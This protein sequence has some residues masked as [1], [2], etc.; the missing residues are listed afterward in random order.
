MINNL[1]NFIY[2]NKI[3]SRLKLDVA[4]DNNVALN[5][6]K[7]VGFKTYNNKEANKW[8]NSNI[9]KL[10]NIDSKKKMLIYTL[11]I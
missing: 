8:L 5:C 2:Q 1:I 9:K 10:Y 3:A 4:C 6:Y 11:K 7:S